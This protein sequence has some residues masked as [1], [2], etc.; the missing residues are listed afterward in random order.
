MI[1]IDALVPTQPLATPPTELDAA[2]RGRAR[3]VR[4]NME[5]TSVAMRQQAAEA[6]AKAVVSWVTGAVAA[7]NDEFST[8]TKVGLVLS[9]ARPGLKRIAFVFT[10]RLD[11]RRRLECFLTTKPQ[12]GQ[13][14]LLGEQRGRITEVARVG[15]QDADAAV[16]LL[17][18]A[19]GLLLET[20]Q[21]FSHGAA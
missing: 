6:L 17:A 20:A 13:L 3:V 18:A 15:L 11:P 1:I 10:D 9:S 4:Q 2:L 19:E 14:A 7:V 5:Q 8:A 12:G 21:T 16:V